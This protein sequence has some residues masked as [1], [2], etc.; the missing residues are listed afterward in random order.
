MTISVF[1]TIQLNFFFFFIIYFYFILRV[2]GLGHW[3]FCSSFNLLSMKDYRIMEE[4]LFV[5]NVTVKHV[6]KLICWEN[7]TCKSQEK[8]ILFFHRDQWC[9]RLDTDLSV[10]P[11]ILHNGWFNRIMRGQNI[12]SN[13]TFGSLSNQQLIW[14]END[15]CSMDKI[16]IL[17]ERDILFS[18]RAPRCPCLDTGFS[19]PPIIW[20]HVR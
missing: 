3:S 1:H 4:R 12:V 11:I 2:S 5:S 16:N 18:H 17:H 9:P 13:V 19:V 10:L 6:K 7:D 8:G 20:H 14:F 15:T